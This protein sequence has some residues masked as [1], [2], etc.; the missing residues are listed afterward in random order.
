MPYPYGIVS[1]THYHNWSA[2]AS[3][4]GE[5][6]NTR[7]R[8]QLSE[9]RKAAK[10]VKAA[11]GDTL[12]HAGDMFHVRGSIPP[13]VLNPVIETYRYIIEELGIRVIAIPGNHDLE[14]N[15]SNFVMNASSAL[16]DV[17]VEINAEPSLRVR[18]DGSKVIM[19]PW[20]ND[21]GDL[22]AEMEKWAD[23]EADCI[24][25]APVDGVIPGI[26]DH[27]LTPDYLGG[28][29]YKRVFAGH[30]HDHK[31]FGNG[32]YSIGALTQQTWGDVG[33]KA[34]FL[35][36]HEDKIEHHQSDAPKF[37]DI[38]ATTTK[39]ELNSVVTDNYI[40]IKVKIT[41]ESQIEE[42][43]E[44]LMSMGAKGVVIN[45][46][47]DNTATARTGA[48]VQAGASIQQSVNEF[49]GLKAYARPEDVK[50]GCADVLSEVA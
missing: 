21:I 36:V 50:K 46:I 17:G 12:Y 28:L 5:G 40:R 48:T 45:S 43:R 13:S 33:T 25:H 6:I 2:F 16:H 47:R 8:I 10:A 3:R 27:G 44:Q 22:K 9:T 23:P 19:I 1:D 38:D 7:L 32:V 35:I 11:G 49:I 31:G 15:D 4:D 20:F 30:Y 29:D 37:V 26:P 18:K 39:A 14:S 34:G 24:I 42:M 41:K